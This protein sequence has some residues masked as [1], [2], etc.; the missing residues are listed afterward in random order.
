MQFDV[1]NQFVAHAAASGVVFY[2]SGHLDEGT[3]AS[4]G[5]LLRRRLHEEG[6]NGAQSRKVF[7]TFMEM[8]QNILHYAALH[9]EEEGKVL[10]GKF[11][12]LCVAHSA[13]GFEVMCGN[14]IMSDQVPRVRGRLEAVQAMDAEHVRLAYRSKL[15]SEDE[16]PDSK[17]A[18]LGLLT[19][20]A[21]SK[22]PIEFL[23]NP[24]PPPQGGST[25]LFLKAII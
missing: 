11:G 24:D 23:F 2:H 22:A 12:A 17:G 19:M 7:T 25:F 13:A 6:A 10:P 9:G 8:A 15:A 18:G 14:Y 5:A 20:A 16:D 1:F 3:I 21:S 4:I